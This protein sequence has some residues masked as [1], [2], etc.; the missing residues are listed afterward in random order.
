MNIVIAFIITI[1]VISLIARL[2][3]VNDKMIQ[4]F[5]KGL[6]SD[7]K[8]S[9]ICSLWSLAKRTNLEDPLSLFV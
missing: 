6:D 3:F 1:A 5:S 9:E 2:Y 4:F 8:F 7:F